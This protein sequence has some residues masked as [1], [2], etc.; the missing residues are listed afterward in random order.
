MSAALNKFDF[1]CADYTDI[2]L[3][4]ASRLEVLRN[5]P[6]L[7]KASKLHYKTHPVDFIEDWFWTHDPRKNPAMMPFILFPKQREYIQWLYEKYLNKEDGLTEKSRDAGVTWLCVAF[8][9]W[10]WVFHPGTKTGFGSRKADLVDKIDDPDCIF[11]KARTILRALPQEFLPPDFLFEQDVKFMRIINRHN[12][13]TIIG[14]SGNNIGRGGRSTMYF[15]DESAFYEQP[16]KIEAS[17]SQ[18]SDVKIDVSTPN[19]NGNPFYVKRF[20]GKIDVFTFHWKDDPRKDEKWYQKQLDTLDPVTVAQEIDIDYS[21]SVEGIC[22]P[23]KYVRAAVNLKLEASGEKCAGLDVADEGGDDNVLL[24]M[25]GVVVEFIDAWKEGNTTQTTRKAHRIAT[26]KG[27]AKV[28]FDSIGVGA[29]VKGESASLKETNKKSKVVFIGVNVGMPPT[30]GYYKTGKKNKDMFVNL[31]AQLWWEL[32]D[33]FERTFEHV[34]NIKKY[35]IDKLISIPND[36][37]L[38]SELSQPKV[39][40]NEAGK[41]KIESK[42]KLARRG[43]KS[44]NKAEALTIARAKSNVSTTH[45]MS[46]RGRVI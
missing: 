35:P 45:A 41:L 7:L 3:E 29:G 10:L 11:E 28:N 19:G 46:R 26:D 17:L 1:K 42:I 5:N 18:N 37:Q 31:K 33:A 12:G 16:L 13:S 38:I 15:K 30:S 20:G 14:E 9:V 25:H 44:P 4:R 43:I 27:Y 39:E 2:I 24:G 40:T 34:N 21:A 22:I 36:P 23:A 8:A 32:R 6:E